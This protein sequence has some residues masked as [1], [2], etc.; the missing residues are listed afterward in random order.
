MSREFIQRI[1]SF[2]LPL[3]LLVSQGVVVG[4]RFEINL[5]VKVLKGLLI[6]LRW[7]HPRDQQTDDDEGFLEHPNWDKKFVAKGVEE[8]KAITRNNEAEALGLF[9][10]CW[11]GSSCFSLTFSS[12]DRFP[13]K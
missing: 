11:C 3:L 5:I 13:E 6:L 4:K 2:L 9:I 7:W 8:E 10:F 12:G 1:K